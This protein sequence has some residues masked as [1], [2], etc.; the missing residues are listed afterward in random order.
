MTLL[1]RKAVANTLAVDERQSLQTLNRDEKTG[2]RSLA[3]LQEAHTG[4]EEKKSELSSEISSLE[5]RKEEVRPSVVHH[6]T[7]ILI[8]I[9]AGRKSFFPSD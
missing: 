5:E 7:T 8:S 1:N 3:G 2:A 4:L 9:S 6:Y